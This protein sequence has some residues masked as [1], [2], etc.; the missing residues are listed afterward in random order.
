MIYLITGA[1][2]NIGS[3]VVDRLLASGARP[4][5]FV[6]DPGKAQMR[7][8]DRVDI[9]VG[10][11][12]DATSLAAALRGIS[13]LFLVNTGGELPQRDA[14]AASLARAAGVERLVKLS[15]MDVQQQ[16]IGTGVWHAR[17]EAAI[18]GS[19][20]GFT[21]VQPAGFMANALAWA[22][23]IKSTG[24]VCCATGDGRIA[25]IHPQDIADVATVALTG[26]GYEGASLPITGP[27]ALSCAQMVTR[28]GAV[29]GR[30]LAFQPICEQEERLRW[31]A[32]G[33]LPESIDYHLSIFRAIRAGRLATVTDNV[34]RILGRQPIGF[35]QWARENASA[36]R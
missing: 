29:I 21:F 26:S 9:A 33:E 11:L 15:T 14:M 28:I 31:G 12:M 32:R 19:G 10:D 13:R 4:R 24:I 25:F 35:D 20:V 7:F 2:G 5:I 18:R 22:P 6:R 3:M 1:T 16:N 30:P 27:E 34:E 36:F 8:G 17:G 23:A